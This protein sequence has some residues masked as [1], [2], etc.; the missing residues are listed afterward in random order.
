MIYNGEVMGYEEMLGC[1]G[2]GIW[3]DDGICGGGWDMGKGWDLAGYALMFVADHDPMHV[4][5]YWNEN[6]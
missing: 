6:V 4:G 1:G 2:D 5:N 3:G